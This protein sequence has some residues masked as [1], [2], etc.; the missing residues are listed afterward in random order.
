MSY[1]NI[2][3]KTCLWNGPQSFY[4]FIY[5]YDSSSDLHLCKNAY[6]AAIEPIVIVDLIILPKVCRYHWMKNGQLILRA[7]DMCN[8]NIC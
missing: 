6:L 3:R 2:V 5:L 1:G 4:I 7:A 8:Q